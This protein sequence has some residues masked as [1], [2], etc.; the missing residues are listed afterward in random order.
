MLTANLRRWAE[1]GDPIDIQAY[2][3]VY[4][5]PKQLLRDCIYL[6]VRNHA[7]DTAIQLLQ[8]TTPLFPDS[9]ITSTSST[10]EETIDSFLFPNQTQR[11]AVAT[12]VIHP[13]L[14]ITPNE[15]VQHVWLER[16]LSSAC[17][18][19]DVAVVL[20]LATRCRRELALNPDEPLPLASCQLQ[21]ILDRTT[22]ILTQTEGLQLVTAILGLAQ[23]YSFALPQLALMAACQG[24]INLLADLTIRSVVDFPRLL[25]E[26]R[27]WRNPH[28]ET[29]ALHVRHLARASPLQACVLSRN[30][31]LLDARLRRHAPPPSLAQTARLRMLCD[32]D[33]EWLRLVQ[34]AGQAWG[35]GNSSRLHWAYCQQAFDLLMSVELLESEYGV[36]VPQGV[37]M[38]V[39]RQTIA[40]EQK[41]ESN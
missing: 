13:K 7:S 9:T 10:W 20:A 32:G 11:D 34:M 4:T 8:T 36:S 35:V 5:L 23:N 19:G 17:L 12:H 18:K 15:L 14:Q 22:T 16:C 31:L 21:R 29:A 27:L 24:Y 6:A 1:V 33:V 25:S 30:Q 3:A 39:V 28:D 2:D 41:C 37:V 40:I 26:H 38:M